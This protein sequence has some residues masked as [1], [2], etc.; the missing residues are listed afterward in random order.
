MSKLIKTEFDKED[1]F[2]NIMQSPDEEAKLNLKELESSPELGSFTLADFK[3]PEEPQ[4]DVKP[5]TEVENMLKALVIN[6]PNTTVE[7]D[8]EFT[9]TKIVKK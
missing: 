1:S 9:I 2:A 6:P 3:M 5:V 7:E 4:A 8:E